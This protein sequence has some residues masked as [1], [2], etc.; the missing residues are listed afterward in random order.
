MNKEELIKAIVEIT[1]LTARAIT[2]VI[3]AEQDVIVGMVASGN[4]VRLVNYVTIT[5]KRRAAIKG[6]NPKNGAPHDIPA[7]MV[8]KVSVGKAFADRVAQLPL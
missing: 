1:G 2:S 8:A 6:R 5:P 7:V 4:T 3:D